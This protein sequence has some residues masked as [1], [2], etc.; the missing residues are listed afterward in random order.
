MPG[1]NHPLPF[2]KPGD[3]LDARF[4]LIVPRLAAGT[5]TVS[6]A[7]ADGTIANYEICD[8][9]ED[10]TTFHVEPAAWPISGYLEL[11]CGAIAIHRS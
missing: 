1:E 3:T 2:M 4:H 11:P 7:I 9:I 6:V 8:Y 5:Y 10:A